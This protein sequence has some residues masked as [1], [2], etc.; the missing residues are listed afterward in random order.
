GLRDDHLDLRHQAL[1]LDLPHGPAEAVA[2]ADLVLGAGTA[3][4]PLDL[5]RRHGAPVAR[6]AARLDPALA[7]PAAQRVET[8]P[9]HA[10]RVTCAV[11]LARH[12]S[13]LLSWCTHRVHST[14]PRS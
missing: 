1:D 3:P 10:C 4:Q 7:V 13:P 5:L 12:P 14:P 11:V 6:I 9:E 8:D 2:R